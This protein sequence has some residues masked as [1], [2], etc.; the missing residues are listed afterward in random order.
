MSKHI[1]GQVEWNA[2]EKGVLHVNAIRQMVGYNVK[3]L[4]LITLVAKCFAFAFSTLR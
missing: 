4:V 2:Y 3:R 1:F